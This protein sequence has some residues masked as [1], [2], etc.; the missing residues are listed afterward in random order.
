MM[1]WP[2]TA[3]WRALGGA[4][5]RVTLCG[6]G[7]LLTTAG[8]LLLVCGLQAQALSARLRPQ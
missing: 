1:R 6:L 2:A 8:R 3:R 5:L 4:A 7:V